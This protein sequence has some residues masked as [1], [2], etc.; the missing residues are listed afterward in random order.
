MNFKH[1]SDDDSDMPFPGH[2]VPG[3]MENLIG[4]FG[5]AVPAVF[6]PELLSTPNLLTFRG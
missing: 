4:Q 1:T 5:P 6:P 2:I 3:V